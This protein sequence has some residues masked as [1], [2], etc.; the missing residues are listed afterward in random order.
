M[1][2]FDQFLI[3]DNGVLTRYIGNESKVVIPFGV[4]KI[5]R[6]VF[7]NR[8]S[9]EEITIP[10]SIEVIED[11]NFLECNNLR[12]NVLDGVNYLGNDDNPYLVLVSASSNI[13]NCNVKNGCKIIM[14]KAFEEN[15]NLLS[16]SIPSSVKNIGYMSFYNCNYLN[17]LSLCDGLEKIDNCAFEDCNIEKLALPNSVKYIGESA[18]NMVGL[19]EI[20]IPN[21]INFIG[22]L[23]FID[24]KLKLN[25]YDQGYYLGNVQNPYLCFVKPKDKNLLSINIHNQCKIIYSN[26]FNKCKCLK[27]II[28][29]EGV[30]QIGKNA[31]KECLELE[32]CNMPENLM[33]IDEEA[34]AGCGNLK[35][36]KFSNNQ[37]VIENGAFINCCSIEQLELINAIV[38]DNAFDGCENIKKIK[39][40]L[41]TNLYGDYIFSGCVSLEDVEVPQKMKNKITIDYFDDIKN[42]KIKYI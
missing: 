24:D 39:I 2:E 21:E 38:G 31:F 35:E 13:N 14:H 37:I 4:K 33:I 25:E 5:D 1:N 40:G 22:H 11:N 34:F 9:I 20:T 15:D 30:L 16:V 32:Y 18:F 42:I 41:N 28:L 3:S 7:F 27:N 23:A 26:A 10:D 12:F 29:P 8:N 19:R 36:V 17:K 6:N